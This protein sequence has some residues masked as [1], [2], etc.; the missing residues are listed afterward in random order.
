[1]DIGLTNR[2]FL[3]ILSKMKKGD[4]MMLVVVAIMKA[5]EGMEQ[6]FEQAL[7]SIIPQVETEKGTLMYTLHRHKKEAGKFLFY[8]KYADKESL[9][10]H[11]ST[12]HFTALFGKIG[13]ML[14][15]SPVIEMY[16]EVSGITPKK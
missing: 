10:E 2:L 1:M 7:K 3:H 4:A 5:K 12:P 9:K 8:E 16:E 11:S 14:D 13:P 6:E 15:G